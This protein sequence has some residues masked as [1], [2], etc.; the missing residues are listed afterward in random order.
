M[1]EILLIVGGIILG[2]FGLW[3]WENLDL[4]S[5]HH[6]RSADR[7]CWYEE[8][9][10]TPVY[11]RPVYPAGDPYYRRSRRAPPPCNW[12]CGD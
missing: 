10:Y 3:L 1:Q 7:C 4:P 6:A 11:E 8:R 5:W 12:D 9:P 2:L